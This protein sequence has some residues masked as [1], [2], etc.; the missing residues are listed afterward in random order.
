MVWLE[1]QD[2]LIAKALGW[3][4]RKAMFMGREVYI[5]VDPDGIDRGQRVPQYSTSERAALK[6]L[7]RISQRTIVQI[8]F[9]KNQARIYFRHNILKRAN[10]YGRGEN[11]IVKAF[12]KAMLGR[13]RVGRWRV[14][15]SIK[16]LLK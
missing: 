14:R 11:A 5:Q 16:E 4:E 10:G 6:A 2:K 7:K 8:S 15:P 3:T 12:I 9:F 13:N 1:K